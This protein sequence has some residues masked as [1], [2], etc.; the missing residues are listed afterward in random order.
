MSGRT[1]IQWTEETWNPARGCSRVS[2]GCEHCYA[3][4][5]AARFSYPVDEKHPE[6]G[7][8]HG[9][10]RRRSN[11]QAAWTGRVELLIDNLTEPLHWRR[12]RRVFVNSMT[13]LFH[14]RLP[15]EQIAAV[16]GVMAQARQH[17]F[18]VLTKRAERMWD[19]FAW[20]RDEEVISHHPSASMCG[21]HAMNLGAMEID[22]MGLADLP[23]P[24][25]NVWLGVSC[26]DQQ[27]AD[28]RIPK[29]LLTPAA[30]RF[31]S[32]EP[33]LEALD[34]RWFTSS[35]STE[36]PAPAATAGNERV[37]VYT[38]VRPKLD[39]VIV[40][41]E[42]G[43]GARPCDVQWIRGIVEQCRAAGVPVFVKQIGSNVQDSGA[44][45][46]TWAGPDGKRADRKGGDP[47]EWLASLRVRQWPKAVA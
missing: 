29:L 40:G 45:D 31:I 30:V 21:I 33:L 34:L 7:A 41:G 46:D 23:W 38:R 32:A 25:P 9:F 36:V 28:E 39:W 5:I 27:R 12:P 19:F 3:E 13:D 35:Q 4:G 24:L 14:E 44:R 1:G 2:P 43:S 20:M 42:S 10:A 8:F 17:T 6:P 18:Q 37:H 16:F 47:A 26:E 11:G 15:F 22:E